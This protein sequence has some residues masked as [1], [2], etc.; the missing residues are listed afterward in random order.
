MTYSCGCLFVTSWIVE[1]KRCRCMVGVSS[2]L[3]EEAAWV[4]EV[5]VL[6]EGEPCSG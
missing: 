4:G 1:E 2:G 5:P 3:E 6:K